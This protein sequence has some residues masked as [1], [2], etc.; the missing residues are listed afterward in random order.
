[1]MAMAGL[2]WLTFLS[3]ALTH[4]LSPYSFA[5]GLIGEGALTVWLLIN[6]VNAPAWEQQARAA[7][8]SIQTAAS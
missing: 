7:M 6:G 1:L 4:Y 5:P 2:G 3:P 8:A